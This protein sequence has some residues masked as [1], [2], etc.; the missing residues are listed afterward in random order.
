MAHVGRD[1][2][3]RGQSLYLLRR[4]Q[5]CSWFRRWSGVVLI[6]AMVNWPHFMASYRLLYM[7]PAMVRRHQWAAIYFPVLLLGY[8]VYALVDSIDLGETS[9]HYTVLYAVATYYLA[10]HYTGQAWGT[11]ATFAYLEGI[12]F[13]RLERFLLRNGLRV[14]AVW[15]IVWVSHQDILPQTLP[16]SWMRV[17][18]LLHAVVSF[19]AVGCLLIGLL[20]FVNVSLRT[21][22]LPP[23]RVILPWLSIYLWYVLVQIDPGAFYWLQISHAIQ[24]MIFPIR[25]EMNR[26]AKS[27]RDGT[28]AMVGHVVL[29]YLV[30][31]GVGYAAFA[32]IPALSG[33]TSTALVAGLVAVFINIHHYFTD[34]CIWKIR[35][36]AVQ[37]DLFAHLQQA[38][39]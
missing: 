16:P 30:L 25:V 7:S 39:R 2:S 37:R 24:Y 13:K 10:L 34:G 23:M 3:R 21:R 36:P 17:T 18:Y 1:Y 26:F 27:N 5:R 28:P 8:C 6:S 12:S 11:T 38:E 32:G 15:Q 4:S 35:N 14:L 29:F 22:R 33:S 20:V 19:M 31:M 9:L